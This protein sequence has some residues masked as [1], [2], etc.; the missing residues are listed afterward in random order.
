MLAIVLIVSL[1]AA[2]SAITRSY[3][4]FVASAQIGS[5]TILG[6]WLVLILSGRWRPDR[7]W[8]DRAGTAI[9]AMWIAITVVEWLRI[10]VI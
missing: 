7:S 6:G 9:G 5:Y 2:G 10:F 8:I 4:V 3:N 1:W